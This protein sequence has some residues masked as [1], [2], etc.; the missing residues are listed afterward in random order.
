[1]TQRAKNSIKSI[2]FFQSFA[3]L[4]LLTRFDSVTNSGSLIVDKECLI[5]N[6]YYKEYFCGDLA[7]YSQYDVKE[8]YTSSNSLSK[9]YRKEFNKTILLNENRK[10]FLWTLERVD[11]L[12]HTYYLKNM[13]F[14]DYYLHAL[15]FSDSI[16]F[17]QR[18][19]VVLNLMHSREDSTFMWRL[20][21][22]TAS[23]DNLDYNNG[24]DLFRIWNLKY[25][26]ALYAANFFFKKT[27]SKR[28]VFTWH[29]HPDTNKKFD[30]H[31][32]CI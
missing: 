7:K 11:N 17:Q 1:M 32:N 18:R 5:F 19:S 20:E 10:K 6:K 22:K 21:N 8:V 2:Y 24:M 28:K 14:N 9:I 12:E 31:L 29:N 15:K 4:I 26:E 13:Y 30:W 16:L 23:L 25:D 27:N 3:I